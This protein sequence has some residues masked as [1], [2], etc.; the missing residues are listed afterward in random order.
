MVQ[1]YLERL[2]RIVLKRS[3]KQVDFANRSS[4]RKA[5][6]TTRVLELIH[7]V[8]GKR[9]HITKRDLFYTDVKLFKKQVVQVAGTCIG[10]RV[11]V[12]LCFVFA[13]RK[14][15]P[16]HRVTALSDSESHLISPRI[17]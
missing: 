13:R 9:I 1:V 4:V 17:G 14:W 7:E 16:Q 5:A 11:P 2:E 6:I 10:P 8:V 15:G 3:F 12:F